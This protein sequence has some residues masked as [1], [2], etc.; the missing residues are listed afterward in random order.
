MGGPRR[1]AAGP[2]RCAGATLKLRVLAVGKAPKWIDDGV[3]HYLR[4]L[5][6][7]SRP[8]LAVVTPRRGSTDEQR[9]LAA[10][11][12]N[13]VA[14]ILDRRGRGITSD[15][16]AALLADWRMAGRD[17]ALLIG[18]SAGF[19]AEARRNA[20]QVLSLSALTLP[21]Q[22]VR[23]LLAEQLYRAWTIL[24]HHPYHRA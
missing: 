22:L 7:A 17:V 18:G 12:Q 10:V 13:E 11:R 23:V 8:E 6:P 4:R 1:A 19:D 24:H 20:T 15:G 3:A 9:L 14:V 5:P 21:H 2:L 16:L